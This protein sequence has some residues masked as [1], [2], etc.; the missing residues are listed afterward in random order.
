MQPLIVVL[1]A[2][3]GSAGSVRRHLSNLGDRPSG[4]SSR[5][6]V[7]DHGGRRIRHGT[8]LL[9]ISSR[10]AARVD[11]RR[12]WCWPD[13]GCHGRPR[14]AATSTRSS[15][16]CSRG[17]PR[18]STDSLIEPEWAEAAQTRCPFVDADFPTKVGR[19][20]Y[21]AAW[22]QPEPAFSLRV[23]AQRTLFAPGLRS[24]GSLTPGA[25][26]L[27]TRMLEARLAFLITGG[28]GSGTRGRVPS[29]RA[30]R[31]VDHLSPGYRRKAA[32]TCPCALDAIR[33]QI[34][35]IQTSTR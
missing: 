3:L 1:A 34:A 5:G 18:V 32:R 6:R 14:R 29:R 12:R 10:A 26:Q 20:P 9:I 31:S 27:L 7:D 23:P 4:E 24:S 35:T 15:S 30:V 33:C 2:S 17:F 13:R 19:M 22:R 28:T 25:A 21:L 16:D 8:T 11:H